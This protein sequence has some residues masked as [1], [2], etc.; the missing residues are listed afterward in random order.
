MNKE[1][2]AERLVLSALMGA[3][4]LTAGCGK[5]ESV[6]VRESVSVSTART[7]PPPPPPIRPLPATRPGEHVVRQGETLFGISRQYGVSVQ[8]LVAWNNLPRAEQIYVGQV[9]RITAPEVVTTE[10]LVPETFEV[11]VLP[12]VKREPRG[13]KEAW[14]EEAWARLRPQTPGALSTTAPTETAPPATP[15]TPTTPATP[16]GPVVASAE[17]PRPKSN[18][19]SRTESCGSGGW[20]WPVKGPIIIRFDEPM[21][22]SDGKIRNR[23]IDISGAP[24]TPIRAAACGK[25][26]YAGSGLIGLGNMV[27]IK[28]NDNYLTA[29][30]HNRVILVEVDDMVAQG[31]VIAE[32]GNSHADQPKLHFEL[33]RDGQPIDPLKYLPGL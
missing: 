10:P 2:F 23:G 25:V 8:E 18:S 20:I 12:D 5:S 7:P 29:Y 33:R 21:P 6:P 1:I 15:V 9:L 11:V 16:E 17:P 26:A 19:S 32:L 28:H 3:F 30:A 31:Q 22:G 13:G 27:I 24:G 4:V 14:S